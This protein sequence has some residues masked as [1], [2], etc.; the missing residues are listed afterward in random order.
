[1]R[2]SWTMG[3]I[4]GA[5][6]GAAATIVAMPYIRPQVNRAIRKGKNAIDTHMNKME[7]GN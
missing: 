6:I 4:A 3:I 7:S 5:M 2:G 1:M